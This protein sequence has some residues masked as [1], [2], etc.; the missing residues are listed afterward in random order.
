MLEVLVLLT[1]AAD[2]AELQSDANASPPPLAEAGLG[3][4]LPSEDADVE[5]GVQEGVT[6][7]LGVDA[8]VDVVG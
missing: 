6:P 7:A 5:D 8:D 3:V 2:P 4:G 1:P